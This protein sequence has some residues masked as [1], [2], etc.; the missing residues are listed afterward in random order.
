MRLLPIAAISLTL[1][2]CTGAQPG[3]SQEAAAPSNGLPFTVTPVADFDSPW[4]MTFLPD[5]W[6]LVTEKAG[7]L[8]LVSPDGKTRRPVGGIPAVD[9]A[10]QGALKDVVLHPDFAKNRL[11]Y[12]SFSE[13]G[14]GGKGVVLARGQL[15]GNRAALPVLAGV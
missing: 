15:T 2:A 10:G 12:F 3:N 4:A 8:L 11:V 14:K 6:M 1:I 7:T 9:S 13:A 5:G